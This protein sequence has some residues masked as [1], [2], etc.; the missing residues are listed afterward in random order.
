MTISNLD[1]VTL[2]QQHGVPLALDRI[3]SR[4]ELKHLRH[5]GDTNIVINLAPSRA[6]DGTHWVGLAVRGR[7]ALYFDSFGIRPDLFVRAWCK[8]HGL[9]LAANSFIVQDRLH[10]TECGRYVVAFFRWLSAGKLS[11]GRATYDTRLRAI[12]LAND[13]VNR[14]VP[15]RRANDAVLDELIGRDEFAD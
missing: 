11:Y 6:R 15:E 7:I 3:V 10:S 14:F 4:D 8:R 9:H 13:F 12:E 1:L 5:T 2:A